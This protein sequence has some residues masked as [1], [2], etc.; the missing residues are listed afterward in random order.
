MCFFFSSR[1][2]HTRC[3]LVTGVQTCA[4]PIFVGASL[5]AGLAASGRHVALIEAAAPPA[6]SP[7]WDE[8]CI[9]IDHASRQIFSALGVWESLASE[10]APILSTHI[11]E[12]GRFGIARFSAE[13]AG[14]DALG[15]NLPLR[16]IGQSLWARMLV[17]GNTQL[18]C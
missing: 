17:L 9:A 7:S 1:R 12:Q 11:S 14:L 2:R 15:Y 5:A 13:D 8:R 16:A 18:H 3:A 6:S 10:A 4:L